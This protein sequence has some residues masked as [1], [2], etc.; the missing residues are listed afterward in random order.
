MSLVDA[1]LVLLALALRYSA[2]PSTESGR[3]VIAE[4]GGELLP[5]FRSY[6]KLDRWHLQRVLRVV[7]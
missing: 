2:E 1:I 3:R 5:E 6:R 4:H 7:E